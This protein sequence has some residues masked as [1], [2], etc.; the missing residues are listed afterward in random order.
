MKKA[1][2]DIFK[3]DNIRVQIVNQLKE[4][5]KNKQDEQEFADEIVDDLVQ[6]IEE[7]VFNYSGND[8]KCKT[9]RERGRFL[10]GK[11]KGN[12]AL[13]IR[14]AI[15]NKT[16]DFPAFCLSSNEEIEEKLKEFQELKVVKRLIPP[17]FSSPAKVENKNN[18]SVEDEKFGS[19]V[20]D[21]LNEADIQISEHQIKNEEKTISEVQLPKFE[22]KEAQNKVED[23]RKIE[24]KPKLI[25]EL[26]TEEKPIKLNLSHNEKMK[27]SDDLYT[28]TIFKQP[29]AKIDL[30]VTIVPHGDIKSTISQLYEELRQV[31]EENA[32]I[33]AALKLERLKV[34]KTESNLKKLRDDNFQLQ[35]QIIEDNSER[36]KIEA[37]HLKL[38]LAKQES[39]YVTLESKFFELQEENINLI[40]KLEETTNLNA[41]FRMELEEKVET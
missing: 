26:E 15:L 28:D 40:A 25:K 1:E 5:L 9:Y 33:N 41:Q 18:Y 11:I 3:S 30:P 2:T 12:K 24:N 31:K 7:A 6:R 10:L 32:E 27:Q 13:G 36:L 35:K 38:K 34:S 20:N 29:F 22:A 16:F 37:S 14:I 19:S 17:K 23:R 8:C 39:N 4:I 21:P